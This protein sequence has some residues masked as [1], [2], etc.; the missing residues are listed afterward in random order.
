VTAP[1][2]RVIFIDDSKETRDLFALLSEDGAAFTSVG[3]LSEVSQLQK[4]IEDLRPDA[5]VLDRWM[6]G[7]DA[8]DAMHDA[9]A[10]FPESRF[11]ILSSDDDP[12]EVDRAFAK[13]AAGYVLKDGNLDVL[14]DAIVRVAAGELV[15]PRPG[16]RY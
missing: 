5:I 3:T 12:G 10:R 15:R 4:V 2:L 11:L 16:Q 9:L 14:A 7:P 13:G 1:R 6:P 8:L